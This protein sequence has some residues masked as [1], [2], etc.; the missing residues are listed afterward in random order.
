MAKYFWHKHQISKVIIY[1][2]KDQFGRIFTMIHTSESLPNA[3]AT[4]PFFSFRTTSD[5]SFST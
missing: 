4:D 3:F 1:C 5:F 2:K